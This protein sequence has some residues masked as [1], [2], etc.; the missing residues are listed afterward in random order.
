MLSS[1]PAPLCR[2][3]VY[4]WL[5]KSLLESLHPQETM[6]YHPSSQ[7]LGNFL[8]Q[9]LLVLQALLR[10]AGVILHHP[11]LLK[12]VKKELKYLSSTNW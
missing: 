2:G 1:S 4:F 10:I 12:M 5:L 6:S 3:K 8:P 11:L 9:Q 7:P